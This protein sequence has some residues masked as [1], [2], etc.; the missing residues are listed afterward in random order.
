MPVEPD[1]TLS[2]N[3][4]AFKF[5]STLGANFLLTT[6]QLAVVMKNKSLEKFS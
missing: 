4:C 5:L 2:Y 1:L 6:S 3:P